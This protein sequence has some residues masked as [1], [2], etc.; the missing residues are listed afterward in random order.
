MNQP[1]PATLDLDELRKQCE[2]RRVR[3][4]GPGGQRRNKVETAVVI[5]H[6]PTRV[7][8]EANERRSQVENQRVALKRL[9]VALALTIRCEFDQQAAPSPLWKTRCRNGRIVVNQNHVD[10][11]AILAEALD[12]VFA[13]Q[14]DVNT[15]ADRLNCS[16]SQLIKLLKVEPRA[17]LLVSDRRR[18]LGMRSLK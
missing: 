10:F 14:F 9:R 17:L 5:R 7:E 1:H 3:R 13:C 4:S 8:A 11:P 6:L 12:A 18:E 16:M 15:T 2:V